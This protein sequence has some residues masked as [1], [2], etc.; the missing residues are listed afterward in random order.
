MERRMSSR[1]RFGVVRG[2]HA[3]EPVDTSVTRPSLRSQYPPPKLRHSPSSLRQQFL[4]AGQYLRNWSPTT[5]RTYGQ[6]LR[7]LNESSRRDAHEDSTGPV[8]R[9]GAREGTVIG[10][11]QYEYP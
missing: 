8:G 4:R 3:A 5:V 1:P 2:K 11:M 7:S 10:R 6:R 9:V